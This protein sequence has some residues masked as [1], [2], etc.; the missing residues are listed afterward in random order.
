VI[1]I[2]YILPAWFII[3]FNLRVGYRLALPA[4]TPALPYPYPTRTRRIVPV[5]AGT[6]I[7]AQ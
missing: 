3:M 7:P 5:P 1:L 4:P 6:G 2:N